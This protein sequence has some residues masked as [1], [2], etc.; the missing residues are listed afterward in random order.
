MLVYLYLRYWRLNRRVQGLSLE[1]GSA[2]RS[3]HNTDRDLRTLFDQANV[4][5]MLLDRSNKSVLYANQTAM[6]AF[7]AKTV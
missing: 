4:V 5:V 7:G 6:T 3:L 1:M 2:N